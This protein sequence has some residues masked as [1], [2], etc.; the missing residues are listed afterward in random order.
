[1]TPKNRTK[2]FLEKKDILSSVTTYRKTVQN[3]KVPHRLIH[4]SA[5]SQLDPN[6]I[7]AS[8]LRYAALS[9]EY[10][11]LFFD[12]RC[13]V[14]M[15]VFLDLCNVPFVLFCFNIFPIS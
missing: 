7:F 10:L 5:Y 3:Y 1:M 15:C 11:C 2:S 4:L 13:I 14:I 8:Q 12:E 9:A 6:S